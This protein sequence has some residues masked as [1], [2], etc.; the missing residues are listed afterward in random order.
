MSSASNEKVM[1]FMFLVTMA[2]ITYTVSTGNT[3]II[4]NFWGGLP[5]FL[6]ITDTVD[7]N[8]V[9]IPQNNQA[10]L[11]V[12]PNPLI[13]TSILSPSNKQLLLNSLAPPNSP[14][15]N[16]YKSE[17]N[18]PV[19]SK[20][21]VD[22]SEY[23]CSPCQKNTNAQGPPVYTVP[24]NYQSN[25]SPRFNPNGLNSYVQYDLPAEKNLAG[26]ANDPLMMANMVEKPR[27]REDF[28]GPKF[29]GETPSQYNQMYLDQKKQGEDVAQKLPVSA[30][31]SSLGGNDQDAFFFPSDRFIFALQKNRLQQFGD[32]IRGDLPCVPCNPSADPS[33]NVWFRPSVTPANALRTGAINVIAGVGNV[34]SQ[35]TAEVQMRSIGG[36]KDTFGG[37]ALAVPDRTP[38]ANIQALQQAALNRVNMGNSFDITTGQSSGAPDSVITTSFP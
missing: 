30:M 31:N 22:T 11:F 14:A 15:F 12:N 26:R 37:V 9:S 34:T 28:S 23:Y 21:P 36:A 5:M 6:P 8:N 3:P 32:P 20:N 38:V 2:L 19:A 7:K 33:S 29:Q 25:L 13:N 27:I 17:I 4:E 24:G 35:Q 16:Q 18:S 10:Q 1:I